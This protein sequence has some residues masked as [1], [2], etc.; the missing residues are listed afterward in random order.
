MRANYRI[1]SNTDNENSNKRD[2]NI[3]EVDKIT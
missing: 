2:K 1:G 3:R